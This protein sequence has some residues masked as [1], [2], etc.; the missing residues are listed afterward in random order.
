M[1]RSGKLAINAYSP[2]FNYGELAIIKS[3]EETNGH[4]IKLRQRSLYA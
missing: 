2:D 3:D 4:K 1:S